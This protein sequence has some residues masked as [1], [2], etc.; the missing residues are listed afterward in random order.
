[1]TPMPTTFIPGKELAGKVSLVTGVD[2]GSCRGEA[3]NVCGKLA[4]WYSAK[5]EE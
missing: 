2:S 4:G 5:S 3:L 1:M